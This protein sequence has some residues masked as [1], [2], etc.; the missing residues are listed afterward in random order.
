MNVSWVCFY[1]PH[2]YEL[3]LISL[4]SLFPNEAEYQPIAYPHLCWKNRRDKI[5][6]MA[7]VLSM[8]RL[9]F[10]V[11]FYVSKSV[12]DGVFTYEEGIDAFPCHVIYSSFVY[13]QNLYSAA[14]QY[15]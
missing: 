7:P 3:A 2:K 13:S 6:M 12:L 9:S 8:P 4:I 15:L 14:Y 5:F 11:D 1:I 10:L